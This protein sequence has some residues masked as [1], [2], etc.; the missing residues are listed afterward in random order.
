M[1]DFTD[2]VESNPKPQK[3]TELIVRNYQMKHRKQISKKDKKRH[4]KKI[5]M[6]QKK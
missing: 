3:Q 4:S 5:L 1:A 6:K 2:T